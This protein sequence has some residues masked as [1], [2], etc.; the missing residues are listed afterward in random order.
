[1]V[2]LNSDIDWYVHNDLKETFDVNVDG[3]DNGDDNI[4]GEWIVLLIVL[5]KFVMIT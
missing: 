3:D 5:M 2:N 1:M 4:G